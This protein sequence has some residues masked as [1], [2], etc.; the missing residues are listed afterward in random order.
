MLKRGSDNT[1]EK[2][3]YNMHGGKGEARVL[4]LFEAEFTSSIRFLHHTI[5]LPGATIGH[6][7]HQGN[8]ELYF[9]LR[10][11]GIM[12]VDKEEEKVGPGDAVLTKSGSSHSLRNV[13]EEP[14]EILVLEA[15]VRESSQDD[16]NKNLWNNQSGRC[17]SG[18]ATGS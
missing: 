1:P 17:S 11:Q 10:G 5:L 18:S 6:H 4:S 14:L 16:K 15:E 12:V 8:E 3:I 2:V 13:G 9:I 7:L